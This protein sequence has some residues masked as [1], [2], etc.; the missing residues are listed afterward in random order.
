MYVIFYRPSNDYLASYEVYV[1]DDLR[2]LFNLNE[3]IQISES[4]EKKGCV[5]RIVEVSIDD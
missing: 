4:L 3:A 5:V 2:I 1:F